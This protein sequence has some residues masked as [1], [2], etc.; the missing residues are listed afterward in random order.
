[1][2]R[3][4]F[5]TALFR[6]QHWLERNGQALLASAPVVIQEIVPRASVEVVTATPGIPGVIGYVT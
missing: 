2:W 5:Y 3:I 1:M 6:T 4:I